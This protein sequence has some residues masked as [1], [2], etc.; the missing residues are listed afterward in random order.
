MAEPRPFDLSYQRHVHDHELPAYRHVPGETPH[1]HRHPAGHSFGTDPG[2][3]A[4]PLRAADW[5]DNRVYL[6]GVD[7]YNLA[8]WWEAH[9]WWEALWKLEPRTAPPALFLQGLIQIAA[10]FIK[11]NQ[12]NAHGTSLLHGH[13]CRKLR[14]LGCQSPEQHYMGLQLGSFLMELEAFD[15]AFPVQHEAA[16]TGTTPTPTVRLNTR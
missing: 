11:W 8:Y 16:Y 1:P 10:G 6:I 9:E 12:G 5:R 14:A 2:A 3:G 15:K 13:G 4:A 7:L